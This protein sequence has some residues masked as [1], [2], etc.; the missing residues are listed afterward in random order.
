MTRRCAA[1]WLVD[2]VSAGQLAAPACD[3]CHC[4]CPAVV[5]G[6]PSP[7]R[8]PRL[9][10]TVDRRSFIRLSSGAA[11]STAAF[12]VSLG[13]VPAWAD[14]HGADGP[15][16]PPP[17]ARQFRAMGIALVEDIGRGEDRESTRRN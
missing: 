14:S 5:C 3:A 12:A 6:P 16:D 8:R 7:T 9:V 4:L 11:V 17:S 15:D 10:S 1:R 13:S 2:T